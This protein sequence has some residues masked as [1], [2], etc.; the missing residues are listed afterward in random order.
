MKVDL[1]LPPPARVLVDTSVLVLHLRGDSTG[2]VL[3]SWA[4]TLGIPLVS[5]LSVLEITQAMQPHEEPSTRS[6]IES[7]EEVPFDGKIAWQAGSILQRLRRRG[8]T[9][10]LPH[11]AIAASAMARQAAVLTHNARHFEHVEG[12]VVLDAMGVH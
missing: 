4:A 12:L 2:E 10:H 1:R 3:L 7:L 8:I 11:A 5:P 6:L 9:I